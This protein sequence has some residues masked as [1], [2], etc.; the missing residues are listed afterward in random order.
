MV[1]NQG[2]DLLVKVKYGGTQSE[3][4]TQ[5]IW[6]N[7][8]IE[9]VFITDGDIFS[10]KAVEISD[11]HL[12]SIIIPYSAILPTINEYGF[13]ND[14]IFVTGEDFDNYV[15]TFKTDRETCPYLKLDTSCSIIL[16]PVDDAQKA[17]SDIDKLSGIR[18]VF[19]V[20]DYGIF[21]RLD[22]TTCEPIDIRNKGIGLR[23]L[24]VVVK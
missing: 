5:D 23:H 8:R 7:Y 14:M 16:N 19:E 24:E 15:A 11:S 3:Y 17:Y 13:D 12:S 20:R 18:Q 10:N 21:Q 9:G 2:L 6:W 22:A 4:D 1:F